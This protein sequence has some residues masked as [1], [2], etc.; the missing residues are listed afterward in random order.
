MKRNKLISGSNHQSTKTTNRALVLKMIC[1]GRNFSRIDISRQTGL[2]KMS[3]TNIVSEL[4]NE[5]YIIEKGIHQEAPS[6]GSSGRKPV[7]LDINT[8]K[9]MVMG[10]YISRDYIHATLTNLKCEN[11]IEAKCYFSPEETENSFI[12]KITS[13]MSSL[14]ESMAGADKKILGIGVS[15]IGPLDLKNGIILDPPNFHELKRIR[16]KEILEEKSGYEVFINNDMNASAL[17]EMRVFDS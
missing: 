2:S 15:C 3:I 7:F 6:N 5:G 10:I 13:L 12:E 14:L 16:I 1:T 9:Y 17:A 11:I 8:E 4:I